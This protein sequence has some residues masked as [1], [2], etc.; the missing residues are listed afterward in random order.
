[1]ENPLVVVLAWVGAQTLGTLSFPA[2]P[3]VSGR[4]A[5][6]CCIVASHLFCSHIVLSSSSCLVLSPLLSTFA[7]T[8]QTETRSLP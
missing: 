6:S 1:M 3:L 8:T 7:C 4:L 2:S 5:L